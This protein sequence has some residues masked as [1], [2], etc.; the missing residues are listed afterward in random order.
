[1]GNKDIKLSLFADNMI[2]Y[3]KS[4]KKKKEEE[5]EEKPTKETT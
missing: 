1:M 4:S 3:L 5:E 2:L